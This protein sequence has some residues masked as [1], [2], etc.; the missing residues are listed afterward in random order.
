[1]SEHQ[2][3]VNRQLNKCVTQ[4]GAISERKLGSEILF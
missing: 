3:V 1:M 2:I 4:F